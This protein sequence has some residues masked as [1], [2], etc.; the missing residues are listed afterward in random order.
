MNLLTIIILAFTAGGP[1]CARAMPSPETTYTPC[2]WRPVCG[3]TCGQV[4]TV[5]MVDCITTNGTASYLY[6]CV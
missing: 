1:L 3:E 4:Y 5:D 2:Y 6:C